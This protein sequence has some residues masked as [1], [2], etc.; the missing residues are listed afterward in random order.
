MVLMPLDVA[1]PHV[2][3]AVLPLTLFIFKISKMFF[4]TGCACRPAFARVSRAGL[5]GLALSHVI[6]RAML[7]G[8]HHPQ[9]VGFF[10]TPKRA[11]ATG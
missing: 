1:P 4:L 3:F 10:R 11:E 5:A 9:D 6:A 2:I 8:F 7:T